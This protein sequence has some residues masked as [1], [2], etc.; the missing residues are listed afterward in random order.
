M[1]II[2]YLSVCLQYEAMERNV[3]KETNILY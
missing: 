2:K 3:N 1:G